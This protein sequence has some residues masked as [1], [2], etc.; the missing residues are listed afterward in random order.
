[1]ILI[2]IIIKYDVSCFYAEVP[3]PNQP[4]PYL[5]PDYPL[6]RV[7]PSHGLLTRRR[8]RQGLE[9]CLETVS[10]PSRDEE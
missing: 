4:H 6:P 10:C 2:Y 8:R 7:S 5:D 3:P 9:L 1:M